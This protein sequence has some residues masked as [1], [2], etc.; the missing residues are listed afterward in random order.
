ML[1]TVTDPT[2]Q[3]SQFARS[4]ACIISITCLFF[5]GLTAVS[6]Q[7]GDNMLAMAEE[8][9][10]LA[11]YGDEEILSI[12][13]GSYQ[14][15]AKAPAV[16]TV[17]TAKDIR[18]MGATELAQVLE[19]VP[20][21]HVSRSFFNNNP[22]F[23][24]RGIYSEYNEQVLLL[25]NGIPYT[26]LQTGERHGT[27]GG[28]PV[29][30]IQRIEVIRGPGSAVYGADAF[31][32]VI[33][34]HTKSREDI[35]STEFGVRIGS[36]DTQDYWALYG[37]DWGEFEVAAMLEYRTTDG[38]RRNITQDAAT[39]FDGIFL[40]DTS[41]APGSVELSRQNIDA[42]IDIGYEVWRFR[43]EYQG[44]RNVGMYAGLGSSLDPNG[45]YRAD[46]WGADLTYHNPEFVTDWDVQ[47]Q[48]SFRNF[49][50]EVEE[51]IFLLPPGTYPG[52]PEGVS[53]NPETWERHWRFDFS[54]FYTGF[55]RHKLR[56]GTGYY[57]GDIYRVQETKNFDILPG[58][59]FWPKVGL[60]DVTDTAG[61]YLP[62]RKRRNYYFSLQDAWQFTND[63]ELT[64]GVRY[65]HY[66][67]FG[68]TVNPR[69][70]LVW[71]TSQ[72]VTNKFMYGSAFRAPSFAESYGMNNPVAT[73]ND[74]LDP[75]TMKT[76]EWAID[77]RASDELRL[78]ANLFHY[79]WDDIIEYV[80]GVAENTG[81]QKGYGVE[82]EGDWQARDDLQLRGS[83]AY[84]YSEDKEADHVSAGAPNHQITLRA[85]WEFE[86]DWHLNSQ[87]N[88]VGKRNRAAGDPRSDLDGYVMLGMTLRY[89][90]ANS[91]WE[92]AVAGRN[93]FN[94]DARESTTG[95]QAIF[96]PDDL[97]LAGRN[98]FVELR[99]SPAK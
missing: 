50:Q 21:L 44:R 25:I 98:F 27:W 42:R 14:P 7:P 64:A 9:A 56:F 20:G 79:V 76:F 68:D 10:L 45:R 18:K 52:F 84:Q 88:W 39:L 59:V 70:A 36:F 19:A 87:A 37:D 43:T 83:Y 4:V 95:D 67:Q 16:A 51:Q 85:D 99:Y 32:G 58:P 17:I 91:P 13:T 96:L 31:A 46:R 60:V 61:V 65:D 63:W 12:A 73:G 81:K 11:I 34:I 82:L 92:V 15:V 3:Q 66:S 24:F 74:D 55:E 5:L 6:A 54:T 47:A 78:G 8:D 33:N 2:E 69:L 53:G 41:Y 57:L 97:P 72:N 77:Y 22:I 29:E 86:P 28:M 75:E 30:A 23:T 35:D 40:N 48:V 62:E 71:S 90:K 80:S 94:T 89:R 1:L 93:L 49:A 38:H 26:S